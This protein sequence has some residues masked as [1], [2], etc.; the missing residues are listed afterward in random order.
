RKG[1][2]STLNEVYSSLSMRRRYEVWFLRLGLADG[3]GAWWFRYL[4][5]NP[6]RRGC[7]AAQPLQVWATWFPADAPPQT[8]IQGFP[9]EQVQISGR[10]ESPFH[11]AV[12]GNAISESSCRGNLSVDG[13]RI[14]WDLQYSSSFRFTMSDKRWVGF[15][16]T[17]H[18]DATF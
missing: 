11:F 13:H 1:F 16:R 3:S 6:G 17:P 2:V 18:S 4:L 10:G 9:L 7:P 14:S 5:M 12:E 15:S 8:F